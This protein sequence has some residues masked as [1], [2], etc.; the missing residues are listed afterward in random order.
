MQFT[1]VI[2][3]IYIESIIILLVIH[4]D[5]PG[6]PFDLPYYG[7][8]N[9]AG[10]SLEW[11]SHLVPLAVRCPICRCWAARWSNL[12][13][14][15][16]WSRGLEFHGVFVSIYIYISDQQMGKI[17]RWC[18]SPYFNWSNF[19]GWFPSELPWTSQDLAGYHDETRSR[20]G[21]EVCGQWWVIWKLQLEARD[22]AG[23]SVTR[24]SYE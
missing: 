4:H 8:C 1:I 7:T 11:T 24:Q 22:A 17:S 10:R 13:I 3:Y 9:G 18:P 14:M 21:L 19:Y 6:K 5:F 23:C 2:T 15:M 12:L 20:Q 16:C